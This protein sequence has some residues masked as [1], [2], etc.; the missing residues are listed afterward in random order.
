[1]KPTPSKDVFISPWISQRRQPTVQPVAQSPSV[2]PV[3]PVTPA[4]PEKP[5]QLGKRPG[6]TPEEQALYEKYEKD[7]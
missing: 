6:I 1:M 3:A 5:K 2:Q 7:W 4:Q